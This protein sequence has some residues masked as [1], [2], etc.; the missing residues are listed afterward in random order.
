MLPSNFPLGISTQGPQLH[1]AGEDGAAAEF[2]VLA[3]AEVRAAD[4]DMSG[5]QL[6][7]SSFS[8]ASLTN[9]AVREVWA[10]SERSRDWHCRWSWRP[11]VMDAVLLNLLGE[12]GIPTLKESGSP[13]E[14]SRE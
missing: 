13:R 11:S 5:V 6:C 3:K 9:L 14:S 1:A 12:I 10:S 8:G 7:S 4:K 2:E